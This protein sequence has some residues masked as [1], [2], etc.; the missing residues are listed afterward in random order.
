MIIMAM[1]QDDG[2]GI[3][4]GVGSDT[5]DDRRG[6]QASASINNHGTIAGDEID[7]RIVGDRGWD[8]DNRHRLWKEPTV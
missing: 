6:I 2:N 5:P 7:V 4:L 8:L 1:R 3:H